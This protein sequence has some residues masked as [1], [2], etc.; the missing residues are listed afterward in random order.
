MA[1]SAG[2]L[3]KK[4]GIEVAEPQII[5]QTG[6]TTDELKAGIDAATLDFP[7]DWVSLLIG[8]NNQYRGRS[9]NEFRQEFEDLLSEAVLFSGNRKERVFV[10]SIPDWGSCHL[11]KV[12]IESKLQLK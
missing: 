8:V 12:V 5:A 4:Y 9:I 10:V 6:W 2:R 3:L 11:L 7:Y 1:S